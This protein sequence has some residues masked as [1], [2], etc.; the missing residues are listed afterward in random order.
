MPVRRDLQLEPIL[1]VIRGKR[2][3]HVH[4]YRQDEMLMTIRLAEEFGFTVGSFEHTLEGYKI[5]DELKNH[6]AAAVVWSDWSS[7]KLEAY[8]GILHNA[9]LL[10]DVGVLTSLHSD[11]T[12]LSTRMNWEAAKS[13][14]NGVSEVDAMNLITINPAKIMGIDHR[15]GSLEEGKDADFVIWNGHPLSSF[16][17]PDQTW[18]DGIKYFDKDEDVLLREEMR[19]ERMLIINR[20]IESQPGSKSE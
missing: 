7:F 4:A 18:V 5:A 8:D 9:K 17:T 10:N 3:A 16:S 12:Q 6:G 1:E 20:I 15:V 2:K 19:A 13:L 14:R 11:N